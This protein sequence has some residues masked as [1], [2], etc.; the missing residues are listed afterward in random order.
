M[1]RALAWGCALLAARAAVA[2]DPT[3]AE[4]LSTFQPAL[5]ARYVV[6]RPFTLEDRG[7]RRVAAVAAATFTA[8][9]GRHAVRDAI[10]DGPEGHRSPLAEGARN[11]LGKG[12]TAPLL[13]LGF[14]TASA[15]TRDPRER[16]TASMLLESAAFSYAAAGVGSFVIASE[17]PRDG[18]DV[19]LLRFGRHGCSAD[20]ALAASIVAPIRRSYLMPRPGDGRAAASARRLASAALYAGVA[21]VA[22]QRMDS[23]A[24]WLPDVVLGAASGLAVG[25]A[26]CDARGLRGVRFGP[27]ATGGTG[28][29]W[30]WGAR[31]A[32]RSRTVPGSRSTPLPNRA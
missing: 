29:S 14:V 27:L 16:R 23:D 31:P 2:A 13:A 12:A 20:V 28:F 10:W 4:R 24:H 22:W 26:V 30:S 1:R 6:T 32:G 18:D 11:L 21:L 9:A 5:D 7:R 17:R 3:I 25:G 15:W 8:Y 19:D